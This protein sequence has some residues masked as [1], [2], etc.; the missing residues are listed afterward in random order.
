[1]GFFCVT[2]R[3]GS[4]R[5]FPFV[6]VLPLPRRKGIAGIVDGRRCV[7]KQFAIYSATSGCLPESQNKIPD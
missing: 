4:S 6:L 7:A 5:P 3:F 1:M 2:G